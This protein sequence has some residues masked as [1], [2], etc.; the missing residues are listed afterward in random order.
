MIR[1]CGVW[2]SRVYGRMESLG[3][4]LHTALVILSIFNQE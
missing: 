4:D 3:T 1:L 2:Y